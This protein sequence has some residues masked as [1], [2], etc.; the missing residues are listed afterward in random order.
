MKK[1]RK[2]T[3]PDVG[4]IFSIIGIIASILVI[5]LDA[6]KSE[7]IG[8]GLGLLIFCLLSLLINMKN[9]NN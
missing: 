1:K 5:I 7:S 6:L 8:V 2:I 3:G 4:I 9:K